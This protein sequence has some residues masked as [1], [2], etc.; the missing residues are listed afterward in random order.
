MRS[1]RQEPRRLRYL[2][3]AAGR[4]RLPRGCVRRENRVELQDEPRRG[5]VMT[6]A[7]ARDAV[8]VPHAELAEMPPLENGD[9]LDQKTFHERYEAMPENVK[10]ELIGG[11]VYMSSPLKPRHG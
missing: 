11:V 5:E 7:T 6:V 3:V 4:R 1:S 10:A 2:Y 9:R 8:P